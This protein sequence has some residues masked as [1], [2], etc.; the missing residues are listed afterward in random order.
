MST[1]YGIIVKSIAG[2]YYVK[3]CSNVFECK[4]RGIF[5]NKNIKPLV[6]DRVE[7]SFDKK[8]ES[9]IIESI[10]SRKNE[11]LRPPIANIDQIL[12]VSSVCDPDPNFLVMDKMIAL[13]YDKNIEPILVI[14]KVDLKDPG[15]ILDIYNKLNIKIAL[16]SKYKKDT[17]EE[18]KGYLKGKISALTGNTGVGKSTLL[19]LIDENLCLQTGQTSK[20][21]GRGKHTTRHVELFSLPFDAFVADT[22]GFSSL[23]I[24]KYNL[25]E[26]ENLKYCFE[27]FLPFISKCKFNSCNHLK[28]SGCAVKKALDDGLISKSRY[29]SYVL[30]EKEFRNQK[31]TY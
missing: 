1:L 9:Y 31:K 7:L 23:E 26:H 4:A 21:L 2:F 8:N 11:L 14:S 5:R 12:I 24:A 27:E 20:K 22:P 19:N 29:E 30:M 6:G 17:I 16:F 18:I 15:F 13:C 25:I 10:K 28:E 3:T